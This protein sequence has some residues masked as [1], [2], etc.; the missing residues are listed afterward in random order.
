MPI[1]FKKDTLGVTAR[2][3]DHL[4]PVSEEFPEGATQ[5][6]L[7]GSPVVLTS[8][9][10][11]QCS[12]AGTT[13]PAEIFG[14]AVQDAH[15]D[16]VA[17]TSKVAVVRLEATHEL[18]GNLLTN[19]LAADLTL[20]AAHLGAR[21][22]LLYYA[23]LVNGTTPG[24]FI[25]VTVGATPSVEIVSF[26]GD[27]VPSPAGRL[28]TNEAQVGDINARVRVRVLPSVLIP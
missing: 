3:S 26:R 20:T 17:G 19:A 18:Y 8:G 12:T 14:I 25:G 28:P 21:A 22:C 6:F 1:T 2:N 16:A 7:A 15:N 10:I 24:W 11:V 4:A 23:T 5:T 27:Q 9:Y 13:G